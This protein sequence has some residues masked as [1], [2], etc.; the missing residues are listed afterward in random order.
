MMAKEE[1]PRATRARQE[2]SIRTREAILRAAGEVFDEFGYA[3]AT[4]Q[5]IQDRAC[6]RVTK[7]GLYHHFSS[8]EDIAR[9]VLAAQVPVNVMPSQ[10]S[11][12]QELIDTSFYLVNLLQTDPL[13][14]GSSRLTTDGGL[15]EGVDATQPFHAWA[16]HIEGVLAQARQA[17]QM[18]PTMTPEEG[19]E[20]LIAAFVGIQLASKV[21]DNCTQLPRRVSVLWRIYLPGIAVPGMIPSLDYAPDRLARLLPDNWQTEQPN[22]RGEEPLRERGEGWISAN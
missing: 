8:K 12:I 5:A 1:R 20:T 17:G 14:R 7:G 3:G 4:L 9:A 10:D 18:L 21:Y 2:R 19:A 11:K 6:Q 22:R 13:A 16:E 15:P